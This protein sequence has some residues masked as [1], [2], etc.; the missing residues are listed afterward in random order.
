MTYRTP[1]R[2]N[3]QSN[4]ERAERLAEIKDEMLELL[5]EAARLTRDTPEEDRARSYWLAHIRIALDDEHSYLGGSMCTMQETIEA[6]EEGDD[7]DADDE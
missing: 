2:T 6:L 4:H 5:R 1:Q 3:E 7:D